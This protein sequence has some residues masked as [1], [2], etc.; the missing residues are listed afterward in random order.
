MRITVNTLLTLYGGSRFSLD[1]IKNMHMYSMYMY[2][3]MCTCNMHMLSF[4]EDGGVRLLRM[5]FSYG[6]PFGRPFIVFDRD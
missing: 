6:S 2:M 3:N 5:G 4:D 1:K